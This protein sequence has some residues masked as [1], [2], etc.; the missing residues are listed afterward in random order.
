MIEARQNGRFTLELITRLPNHIDW[1]AA[2]VL[3]FF[4]SALATFEA[5]IIG[6][7]DAAHSPMSDNPADLISA[8][9]DLSDLEW[10]WH[11]AI[12]GNWANAKFPV[13]DIIP[14]GG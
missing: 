9:Q 4:E 5:Q 13:C 2:I 12:L 11:R 1:Q 8:A 6:Q 3:D 10:R 7:V 14:G